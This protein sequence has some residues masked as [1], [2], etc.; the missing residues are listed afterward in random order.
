MKIENFQGVY[1]LLLTPFLEDGS[2]DWKGYD[3]YVDWQLSFQPHGLF[4]VCGSSE[5]KWLTLDER[6]ELARKAV[7]RAGKTPV[8]ATANVGD[9]HSDHLEELYRISNTGVSA[10]VLVPP[11]GLGEDQDEL[12]KYFIRLIEHSPLPVI[13]YEWPLV[14]PYTISASVYQELIMT[15]KVIGIKDTTCQIEGIKEKIQAAP[16]SVVYQANT[17][18]MLEALRSGAKGIMAI[19]T[20]AGS[21]AVLRFWKEVL[22]NG[23]RAEEMYR[24]LVFLD[25][26]LRFSYPATAKYL[27][28]LQ[29]IP[30]STYCRA[31]N[32]FSAEA[33]KAVKV[34]L[35]EEKR[36]QSFL[37]VD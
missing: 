27:V 9:D 11:N 26:V 34:W 15:G 5:M 21:E 28:S 7:H 31:E 17:P 25:G 4:A 8:V 2:L 12:K 13:L 33:C 22:E 1:S 18:F 35:D 19:I 36:I 20:A 24:H 23:D 6:V 29:G 30:I 3:A 14:H 37:K 32:A 16:E 10:I